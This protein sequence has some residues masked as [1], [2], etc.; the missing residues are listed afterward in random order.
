MSLP[1]RIAH[2]LL[3]VLTWFALG[4]GAAAAQA[5]GSAPEGDLLRRGNMTVLRDAS[6]LYAVTHQA[7][8]LGFL[9]HEHAITMRDWSATLCWVEGSPHAS[10]LEVTVPTSSVRLDTERGRELAGLASSPDPDTVEDLQA[11]M[12]SDAYLDA[13]SFPAL[14]FS[15]TSVEP[16]GE[17]APEGAD[18][19]VEGELTIHGQ[20]QPVSFPVG[21][22]RDETGPFTFTAHLAFRMTAF[23]I[24]PENTAGVVAVA[25]EMDLYVE[26]VAQRTQRDCRR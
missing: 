6:T 15:T 26:M 3:G 17:G 13:A 8:L 11:E 1:R 7:G 18:L 22:E 20:T 5:D 9:G 14:R 10:F 23:G 21:I 16:A 12:L 4:S 24:T 19:E 2:G 25:D